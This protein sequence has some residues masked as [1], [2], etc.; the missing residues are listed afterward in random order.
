MVRAKKQDL[1]WFDISNYEFLN[2][3]TLPDLIQELEWR[4]FLLRHAK[5]DTAIFKEE[6]D[7]KYERI[8]SGDPNLTILNEE[9]EEV[10][11][12][13]RK[14]NDEAPS[15]RNE[16]DDLPSLSSAMGVSPVTFSELAMYS[17][18]SI[19]QGFFKRDEEDCYLKA[20]AMLA[21]V[22]GNLSNCSPNSILV[23]IDLDDATDDEIITSLTHL[24]PL[25]RKE[26]K[27]PEREHVAQKRIGL[28][29]LQKLISNRV[30]PIVDLLI[31]GEK[32]GKEVSNPMISALVF[33]DDPKDTQAIKESIKPFAL[34]S[35]SERYTR[36]LQLYVNKD[37]EMSLI[38]ISDLMSR[39]L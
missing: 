21:S 19:D 32:S 22:T 3:L 11:E 13:I 30:I 27:V 34:E 26:L 4:D 8:F 1:A 24:L 18:S 14:V 6:Y 39:D 33:S 31:W 5:D 38:K 17:F 29:T 12:F 2:D 10:E 35:I 9:E 25:W 16:Y 7:I 20:N 28:K 36:L 37:R 23:S 15:L